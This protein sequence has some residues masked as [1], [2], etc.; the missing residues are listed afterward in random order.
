MW[1]DQI[2]VVENIQARHETFC[3]QLLPF[4]HSGEESS[5]LDEEGGQKEVPER[6]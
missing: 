6:D 1:I 3:V 2:L 5:V 4:L